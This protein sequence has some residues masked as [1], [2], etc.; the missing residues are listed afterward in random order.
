[1]LEPSFES[2]TVPKFPPK[3]GA[4]RITATD[5]AGNAL[6]DLSFDPEDVSD[7]AAGT[8]VFAFAIPERSFNA[9]TLA[10]LR[11]TGNGSKVEFAAT[12]MDASAAPDTGISVSERVRGRS[13]IRWNARTFPLL[14][15]RDNR[16]GSILSLARG[17]AATVRQPA[18]SL[19][20]YASNGI[21]TRRRVVTK[22]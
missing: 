14:V 18:A 9:A 19:E 4:Y 16:T 15:V 17:G 2:M 5:N 1:V 6:V 12:T 13:E 11:L 22:R 3:S 20:I 8:K 7:A 21:T 10:K